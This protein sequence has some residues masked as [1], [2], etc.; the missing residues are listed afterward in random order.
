M[1]LMGKHIARQLPAILLTI[2]LLVGSAF[3]DLAVPGYI[4]NIVNVGI[5]QSGVSDNVP[6]QIAVDEM[7]RLLV[8]L[9]PEQADFVTA[10]SGSHRPGECRAT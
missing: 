7:E 9:E 1:S 10:A 6:E 8:L 5:Q 2:A 4:A 3:L